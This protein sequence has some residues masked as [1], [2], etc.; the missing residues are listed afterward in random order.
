MGVLRTTTASVGGTI[1][2]SLGGL[3]LRLPLASS[4]GNLVDRC[5]Q[6]TRHHMRLGTH[7]WCSVFSA[8][9]DIPPIAV[10]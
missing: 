7:P 3:I 9:Q 2:G 4:R 6:H 5:A 8:L 10:W 1:G